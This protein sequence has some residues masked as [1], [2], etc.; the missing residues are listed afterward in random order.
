MPVEFRQDLVNG[1][2]ERIAKYVDQGA[3]PVAVELA[4]NSLSYALNDREL[5]SLRLFVQCYANVYPSVG[6]SRT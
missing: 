5:A 6:G 4:L 3:S 2:S 1:L